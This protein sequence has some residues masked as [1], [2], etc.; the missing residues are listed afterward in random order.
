I[1]CLKV[2]GSG[3]ETELA[4]CSSDASSSSSDQMIG[5]SAGGSAGSLTFHHSPGGCEMCCMQRGA[6]GIGGGTGGKMGSCG[7]GKSTGTSS[8]GGRGSAGT[9]TGGRVCL[10]YL[11]VTMLVPSSGMTMLYV[12][13]T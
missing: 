11:L 5:G 6:S 7:G 4:S 13:S 12:S 10:S 3:S 2:R 8:G 9:G 1:A